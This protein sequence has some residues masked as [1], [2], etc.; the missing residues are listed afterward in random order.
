VVGPQGGRLEGVEV[1]LVDAESIDPERAVIA[2]RTLGDWVAASR[3]MATQTAITDESGSAELDGAGT[4]GFLVAARSGALF[5]MAEA[6]GGSERGD[7]LELNLVERRSYRVVLTDAEGAPATGVQITLAAPDPGAPD[8]PFMLPSTATTDA[9]GRA[10]LFEPPAA[11]TR[12]LEGLDQV[13]E[14]LAI[15]RL[16]ARDLSP[17]E[18]RADGEALP[19]SLPPME[20]L[21]LACK[22]A[23]FSREHWAGLVQVFPAADGSRSPRTLAQSFGGGVLKLPFVGQGEDLRAVAVISEASA[24]ERF[25][26]TFTMAIDALDAGGGA[27]AQRSV[28]LPLDA[29]LIITGR[30]VDAKG[31]GLGEETIDLFVVGDAG[32]SWTQVT[33]VEG[34]FRWLLLRPG[35]TLAKVVVGARTE[36]PGGDLRGT[37]RL[38]DV[39][40]GQVVDLGVLTLD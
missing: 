5:G 17:L 36:R 9:A 8:R 16:A 34:R 18:L 40:P 24:P 33:D 20:R 15:L 22:H 26:G 30:C 6:L 4:K 38:G 21:E 12:V 28:E 1:W 7:R 37:A 23:A 25:L 14:R 39:A 27:A 19:W 2:S 32:T 10:T 31:A 11:A 13:P 29:G 3:A 35:R